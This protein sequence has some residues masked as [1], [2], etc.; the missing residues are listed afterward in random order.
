MQLISFLIFYPL[1]WIVSKVPFRILYILSDISYWV[2]YRI[3]GYRKKTVRENLQ[4]ALPHF[5]D[6]KRKQVEKKFYQ[7]F[8]DSFLEMIKTMTI[9]ER[10]M[11]NRFKIKN[12][13]LVKE[14][15]AKG[16]SVILVCA[17]YSSYEW[18]LIMNKYLNFKGFGVYKKLRNKYFDQM[19]RNVRGKF[20]GTLVNSKDIKDTL[21]SNQESGIK[22]YYGFVSD[23]SPKLRKVNHFTQFFGVNVPV[24]TG[25][26][27]LAKKHDMSIMFVKGKKVKRGYYTAEFVSPK[28][29]IYEYSDYELTDEFF[30]LLESQILEAPEYY[31]WTHKRFKHKKLNIPSKCSRVFCPVYPL[32]LKQQLK[33]S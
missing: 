32:V 26:E 23:Q 20:G 19:I 12:I 25:A 9:S 16:K 15:E 1:L 2:L 18:L 33:V 24:F 8:C 13:D 28:K 6:Y 22:G 29:D 14:F 5:S 31:L 7:H 3:V 17:H 10:E 11:E 21:K 30:R 27:F 4:I